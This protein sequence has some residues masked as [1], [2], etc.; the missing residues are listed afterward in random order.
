MLLSLQ[1]GQIPLMIRPSDNHDFELLRFV[2]ELLDMIVPKSY[3]V[4]CTNF[5]FLS[6]LLSSLN[7][8]IP[9]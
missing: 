9:N 3:F 4:V 8:S 5:L 7:Q 1:T 6:S 2:I